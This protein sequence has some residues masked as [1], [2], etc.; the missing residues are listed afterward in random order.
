MEAEHQHPHQKS[1]TEETDPDK[2]VADPDKIVAVKQ[3]P[4][5]TTLKE[6]RSFL[7]FCGYY[8]RFVEK[9]SRIAGPLHDLIN[10]C[11]KPVDV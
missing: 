5:P 7:G 4:V 9:C 2:I 1:S 3:W 11:L 8:R 10:L 6:L